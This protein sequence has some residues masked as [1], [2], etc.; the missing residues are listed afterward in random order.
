MFQS[1]C[2]NL[3]VMCAAGTGE[4]DVA[5]AESLLKPFRLRY[6]RV[7]ESQSYVHHLSRHATF[8]EEGCKG[9]GQ[10]AKRDA[11]PFSHL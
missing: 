9:G 3:R 1:I 10:A 5:E 2:F 4:A 7:S 8:F 11:V 6:P